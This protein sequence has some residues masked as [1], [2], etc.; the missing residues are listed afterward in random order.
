MIQEPGVGDRGVNDP[1]TE[2]GSARVESEVAGHFKV[3][4]YRLL[5][6]AKVAGHLGPMGRLLQHGATNVST[7]VLLCKLGERHDQI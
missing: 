5:S 6:L 3:T 7:G 4:S 1:V 2:D